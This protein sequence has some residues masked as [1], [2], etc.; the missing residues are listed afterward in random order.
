M[1]CPKCGSIDIV[2]A[3]KYFINRTNIPI[4]RL[5]CKNCNS[6][7]T[8]RNSMLGK[9]IPL[10][11]RKKVL[12]LWKTKKPNK[13]KFDALRKKTYST[14]DISQLVGVSKSYVWEIVKKCQ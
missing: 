2:Y 3:G 4:P 14:R 12:R 5:R 6:C 1:P 13:N 11:I 8:L 9:K 10:G 7:F